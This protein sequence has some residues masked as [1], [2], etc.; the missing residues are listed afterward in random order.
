MKIPR[1]PLVIVLVV[2]AG[3]VHNANAQTLTTLYVFT[4]GADGGGPSGL[5]QGSD[6]N[7]YGTTFEGGVVRVQNQS[8]RLADP[9]V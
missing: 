2:M 3:R 8:G 4:G 5:V 6:G 9:I 7:F 1:I